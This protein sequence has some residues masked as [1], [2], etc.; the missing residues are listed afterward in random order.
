MNNPFNSFK[1]RRFLFVLLHA[2]KSIEIWTKFKLWT[3]ESVEFLGWFQFRMQML[4]LI[5]LILNIKPQ[6]SKNLKKNCFFCYLWVIVTIFRNLMSSSWVHTINHAKLVTF[7]IYST[8]M[9]NLSSIEYSKCCK[10]RKLSK[11]GQIWTL[12]YLNS[13][14]MFL[15]RVSNS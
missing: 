11:R 14:N 5:S 13:I 15:V 7:V 4:D 9:F 3:F 12:F 2:K 1:T 10:W 8:F 6:K